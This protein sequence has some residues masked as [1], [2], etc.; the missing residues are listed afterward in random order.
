[1]LRRGSPPAPY[2]TTYART[3]SIPCPITLIALV[4]STSP[5]LGPPLSSWAQTTEYVGEKGAKGIEG[6]V[7]G[8][9]EGNHAKHDKYQTIA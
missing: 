5:T 8:N 3:L 2:P 9:A 4:A 1:M 6:N 7:E